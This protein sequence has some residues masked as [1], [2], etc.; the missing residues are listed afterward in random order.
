[1]DNDLESTAAV[2]LIVK[3]RKLKKSERNSSVGSNIS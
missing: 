2:A 1:M 3:K